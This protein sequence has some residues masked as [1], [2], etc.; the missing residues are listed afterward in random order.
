MEFAALSRLTGNPIYEEKAHRAMEV[1]W[2]KRNE[3]HNLVG[4]IINVN[5]GEWIRRGKS[6]IYEYHYCARQ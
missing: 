1:I 2:E 3:D 6:H 5:T 4:T